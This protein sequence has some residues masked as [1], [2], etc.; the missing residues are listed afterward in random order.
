[1]QLEK[2]KIVLKFLNAIGTSSLGPAQHGQR[3][4][5]KRAMRT[6]EMVTA[7]PLIPASP[8]TFLTH[9]TT[10]FVLFVLVRTPSA[11]TRSASIE[12]LAL[13]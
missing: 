8:S 3:A 13:L 9:P 2:Q 5:A 7:I 1:M 6:A 4:F 10:A 12:H 11:A